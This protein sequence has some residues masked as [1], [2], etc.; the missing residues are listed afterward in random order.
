MGSGRAQQPATRTP[1]NP[2]PLPKPSQRGTLGAGMSH[3][4]DHPWG[5]AVVPGGPHLRKW[6]PKYPPLSYLPQMGGRKY[7]GLLLASIPTAV[8]TARQ[9][10]IMQGPALL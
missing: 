10:D 8:P 3:W 6:V 5:K 4:W 1:T 9:T 7:R 2:H